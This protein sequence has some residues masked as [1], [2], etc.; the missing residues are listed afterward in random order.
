[1]VVHA[2]NELVTE[3]VAHHGL[4]AYGIARIGILASVIWNLDIRKVVLVNDRKIE[5]F[6]FA[7]IGAA[8]QR[9]GFDLILACRQLRIALEILHVVATEIGDCQGIV[10]ALGQGNPIERDREL[11]N[12]SRITGGD[13]HNFVEIDFG[14]RKVVAFHNLEV[15]IRGRFA[16]IAADT[17]QHADVLAQHCIVEI[18]GQYN[19]AKVAG[20]VIEGLIAHDLV[21]DI[22]LQRF[23]IVDRVPRFV[24]RPNDEAKVVGHRTNGKAAYRWVYAA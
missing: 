20:F 24:T 13:F 15:A 10:L 16:R 4:K 18:F 23:A 2:F 3:D 11:G 9:H 21:I 8:L 19:F 17:P 5:P 22:L 6:C 14:K 12:R 1:M 7:Q